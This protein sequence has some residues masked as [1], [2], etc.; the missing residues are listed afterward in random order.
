MNRSQSMPKLRPSRAD[1]ADR[2][3]SSLKSQALSRT[4]SL[5]RMPAPVRL[6]FQR[7]SAPATGP[8]GRSNVKAVGKWFKFQS[9][10]DGLENRSV[11][12]PQLVQ[13]SSFAVRQCYSW[14]M[15]PSALNF[16]SIHEWIVKPATREY[17]SSMMEHL[18]DRKLVPNWFVSHFWGDRMQKFLECLRQHLAV[19]GLSARTGY[20]LFAFANR[21]HDLTPSSM[22]SLSDSHAAIRASNFRMLMVLGDSPDVHLSFSRAWCAYEWALCLDSAT[23]SVDVATLGQDVE[24]I[25]SGLT[26]SEVCSNKYYPG[27]GVTAKNHREAGFPL[28]VV[29]EAL[30]FNLNKAEASDEVDRQRLTHAFIGLAQPLEEDTDGIQKM[31]RRLRSFLLLLLWPNVLFQASQDKDYMRVLGDVAKAIQG[32]WWRKSLRL[33]LAGCDFSNK[34]VLAMG[35]QSLPK[36]LET[37]KLDLQFTGLDDMSLTPVAQD[38]PERL[39]NLTLDLSGCHITDRGVLA[40]LKKLSPDLAEVTIKMQHTSVSKGLLALSRDGPSALQKWALL[41]H[42]ERAEVL[43]AKLEIIERKKNPSV[44]PTPAHVNKKAALESML[45]LAPSKITPNVLEQVKADL[46]A[47]EKSIEKAA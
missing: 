41:S 7:H 19:R 11:T 43:A 27:S 15:Q 3:G 14:G 9:Y 23:L 22:S 31:T 42:Q 40:F 35:L 33:S 18:S 2:P 4:E 32:D 39:Q 30:A 45:N 28:H 8:M 12:M 26:T 10:I 1:L 36:S 44:A 29:K 13:I 47:L 20:W 6:E 34:E 16:H 17:N 21:H 25:T 5:S 24:I 46:A 38:L 37:L